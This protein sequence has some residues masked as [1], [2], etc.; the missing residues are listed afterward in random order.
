[1]R[2][3]LDQEQGLM[4]KVPC[5]Q[6]TTLWEGGKVGEVDQGLDQGKVLMKDK[7]LTGM[8]LMINLTQTMERVNI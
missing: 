8:I 3:G 4:N 2:Q 7:I 6:K 1:M 5:I